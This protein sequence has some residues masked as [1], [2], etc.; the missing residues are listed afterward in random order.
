M[1]SRSALQYNQEESEIAK[2][3][4][5]VSKH[6]QPNLTALARQF[7]VPYDR[8]R[9]RYLGK[10]SRSTRKRA[11]KKLTELQESEI[12][13]QISQLDHRSITRVANQILERDHIGEY[14]PP[15][16]SNKWCQRFIQRNSQQF[17]GEVDFSLFR[18]ALATKSCQISFRWRF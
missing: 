16:V 2:A 14:P 6:P 3:L 10:P 18:K 15:I 11:G 4:S 8:L 12:L 13:K 7:N 9:R 17:K 1:P 5:L